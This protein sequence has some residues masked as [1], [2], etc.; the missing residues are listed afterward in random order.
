[1]CPVFHCLVNAGVSPP[2]C[3][4][5]IVLSLMSIADRVEDLHPI[6]DARGY[7]IN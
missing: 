7:G 4:C 3:L 5:R 2:P 1:M 6:M